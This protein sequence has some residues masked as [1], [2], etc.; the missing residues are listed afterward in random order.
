[1]SMEQVSKQDTT[2]RIVGIL[3]KKTKGKVLIVSCCMYGN[4][5]NGLVALRMVFNN[6][7]EKNIVIEGL[8]VG[9]IGN[10]MAHHLDKSFIDEN[11]NYMWAEASTQEKNNI[12]LHS[13]SCNEQIELKELRNIIQQIGPFDREKFLFLNL[14]TSG[15]GAID[16]VIPNHE[17]LADYYAKKL[18]I[19]TL[20]DTTRQLHSM[21]IQYFKTL[22]LSA[23]EIVVQRSNEMESITITQNYIYEMLYRLQL[24]DKHFYENQLQFPIPNVAAAVLLPGSLDIIF[25]YEAHHDDDFLILTH[26]QSFQRV[27]KGGL[28]AHDKQGPIFAAHDGFLLLQNHSKTNGYMIL[29]EIHSH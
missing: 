4:D 3:G 18:N 13:L 10:M 26:L 27:K 24:I 2:N 8:F 29:Q 9:L 28:I 25:K 19:T 20:L 22:G 1:M 21:A 14:N 11:L 23:M 7:K 16:Y 6:L 5:T 15:T 12:A 17:I